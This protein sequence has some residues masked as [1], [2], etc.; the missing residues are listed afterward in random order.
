MLHLNKV[1]CN[2]GHGSYTIH[3]TADSKELADAVVDEAR[4][5]ISFYE[6]FERRKAENREVNTKLPLFS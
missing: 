6:A 4:E 1:T 5:T 2:K 3:I